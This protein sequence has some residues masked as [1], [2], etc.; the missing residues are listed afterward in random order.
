[1]KVGTVL[2]LAVA[3]AWAA[4]TTP[5]LGT[6]SDAGGARRRLS[7]HARS[8]SKLPFVFTQLRTAIE[9]TV[10]GNSGAVTS[11]LW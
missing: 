10:T 11:C 2:A 1:M 4:G 9:A 6:K 8:C 3:T 7:R 5:G